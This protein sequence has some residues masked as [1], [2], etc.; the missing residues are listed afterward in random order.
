V[1]LSFVN[2]LT[3]SS[4][5]SDYNSMHKLVSGGNI[6]LIIQES[7]SDEPTNGFQNISV[8]C[9]RREEINA[10]ELLVDVTVEIVL[11]NFG[12]Q[13]FS[14]INKQVYHIPKWNEYTINGI[15]DSIIQQAPLNFRD[16]DDSKFSHNLPALKLIRSFSDME[17]DILIEAAIHAAQLRS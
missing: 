8:P 17:R 12:G 11:V 10:N 7:I 14:W 3:K 6:N 5:M 1:R 2:W 15:L 4:F 16:H 9:I 13:S